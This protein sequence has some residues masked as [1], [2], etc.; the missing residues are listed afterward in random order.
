MPQM[1]RYKNRTVNIEFAA[2]EDFSNL[3]Y[4]ERLTLIF[5]TSGSMSGILNERPISIAAPG[6]LCLAED[7]D[8]KVLE[9]QNIAAQSFSFH[10]E[11]LN[12]V[13]LSETQGYFPSAPR[14]QTG[15]SF[16]ESD[17]P[18]RGVPRITEK[19]YPLLFE[20]FFVLGTEVQAQSDERWACRIKKIL[21]S[22]YGV[23]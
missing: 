14:I 22:N 3:P 11:F 8:L 12:S 18:N 13:T 19:A 6:V 20:W 15:L 17:H 7:D 2:V 16:F 1:D 9:K 10:P 21:Y 5:I 4:P 23:A